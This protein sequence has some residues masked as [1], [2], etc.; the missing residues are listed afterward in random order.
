[1]TVSSPYKIIIPNADASDT[2]T[3]KFLL[4]S[5]FTPFPAPGFN[6]MLSSFTSL[7]Y[8]RWIDICSSRLTVF[9]KVKDAT[10]LPQN[11][12][13]NVIARVYL[14]PPGQRAVADD[15]SK[16][17]TLCVDYNTPKHLRWDTGQAI[18]DFD[19]Q[20]RDEFGD[21]LYWDE[22]SNTEFE[23]TILASES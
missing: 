20:V 11:T 3:Q 17:F 21:L 16:P 8:T 23:M 7:L 19:I 5:G 10:T 4:T 12:N 14:C 1:M 15:F 22:Y 2:T 18:A 13:Q 6:Q 9:Q